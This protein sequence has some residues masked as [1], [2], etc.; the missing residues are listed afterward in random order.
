MKVNYIAVTFE[1]IF[2]SIRQF[3]KLPPTSASR[4][5][6]IYEFGNLEIGSRSFLAY[7]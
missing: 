3:G 2:K 7:A 1:H 6:E 5:Q 4:A